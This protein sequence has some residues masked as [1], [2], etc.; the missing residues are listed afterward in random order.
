MTKGTTS[1]GKRHNKT[2]TICRRCGKSSFHIQKKTCAS[3]GFPGAK[4]R[5]Y[6]QH[7]KAKRRRTQGTGRMR[8]M[9]TL[10]R[11]FKNG[12]REG[13]QAKRQSA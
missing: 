8:F 13:T 4:M 7:A 2:H 5:R 3:C 9:K 1:F 10:P 12:F 6:N 11:R